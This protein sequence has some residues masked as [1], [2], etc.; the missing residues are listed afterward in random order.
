MCVELGVVSAEGQRATFTGVVPR[1]GEDGVGH[2]G[3]AHNTLLPRRHAQRVG[4]QGH[5]VD[6]LRVAARRLR[7]LRVRQWELAEAAG[8]AGRAQAVL[9]GAAHASIHARQGTHH[10]G[11]TQQERRH[12][13]AWKKKE[14]NTPVYY[15]D[16][17]Q[18]TTEDKKKP[19]TFWGRNTG[20]EIPTVEANNCHSGR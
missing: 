11:E 10:C 2:L 7:L 17:S 14:K 20:A 16:E 19:L 6:G 5:G 8:E 1:Q 13:R 9:P 4:L 15:S 3:A 12:T 18:R